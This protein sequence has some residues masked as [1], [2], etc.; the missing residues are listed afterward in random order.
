MRSAGTARTAAALSLALALGA[1]SRAAAVEPGLVGAWA[2]DGNCEEVFSRAG[3]GVAF[4]KP[5][6]VFAPAFIITGNRLRT[7]TAS[8]TIKGVKPAGD[9]R[10]LS[11]QCATAIAVDDVKAIVGTSA[12][13]GL[14]RYLNDQDSTG[15]TYKRCAM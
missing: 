14:V 2:Q 11:L 9:R 8:C 3:K 4:K 10:V 7:P 15:S 6:N 5:V 12:D 1:I 13:G